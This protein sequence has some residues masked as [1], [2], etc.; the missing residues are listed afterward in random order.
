MVKIG[1]ETCIDLFLVKKIKIIFEK[2]LLP[3]GKMLLTT[4][5]VL[6]CVH[7]ATISVRKKSPFGFTLVNTIKQLVH[8]LL[9]II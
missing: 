7:I 2:F 1:I 6:I 3:Q 5:S 9:D 4:S 8:H